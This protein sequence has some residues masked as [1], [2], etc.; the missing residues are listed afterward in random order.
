[1]KGSS[2]LPGPGKETRQE[3]ALRLQLEAVEWERKMKILRSLR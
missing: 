2:A 1:M 3:L